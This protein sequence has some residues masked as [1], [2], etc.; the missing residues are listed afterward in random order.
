MYIN[1]FWGGVAATVLVEFILAVCIIVYSCCRI[2]K[3]DE[4]DSDE[5]TEET[6]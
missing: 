4:E 5:T 3:D 2:N 1:P 6:Y